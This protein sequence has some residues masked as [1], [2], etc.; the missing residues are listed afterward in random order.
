MKKLLLLTLF[1]SLSPLKA[2][3]PREVSKPSL[4]Q[5][6]TFLFSRALNVLDEKFMSSKLKKSYTYQGMQRI[7]FP[8]VKLCQSAT[9]TSFPYLEDFPKYEPGPLRYEPGPL[10]FSPETVIPGDQEAAKVF[11]P[12]I[13]LETCAPKYQSFFHGASSNH[14]AIFPLD[15]MRNKICYSN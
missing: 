15:L 13:E 10:A 4:W 6:T 1:L 9:L 8:R 12:I 14:A 5:R 7:G 11:F 2:M 3:E